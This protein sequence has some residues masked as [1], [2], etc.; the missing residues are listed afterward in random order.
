MQ[1]L[2]QHQHQSGAKGKGTPK[3]LSSTTEGQ[4]MLAAEQDSDQEARRHGRGPK[5]GDFVPDFTEHGVEVP[6]SQP[7]SALAQAQGTIK[8]IERWKA[9]MPT[10]QEMLPKDKYTIFDRKAKNYRKG[11]RSLE[12]MVILQGANEGADTQITQ[13][14]ACV[15]AIKSSWILRNCTICRYSSMLR[16]REFQRIPKQNIHPIYQQEY[17]PYCGF[18]S[19]MPI[20]RPDGERR[21]LYSNDPMTIYI[22]SAAVLNQL[23]NPVI[24]YQK[25]RHHL[26]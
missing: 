25:C 1:V 19:V 17:S 21:A 6:S 18:L 2:N 13:M 15:S 11:V 24:L 22:H 9:E 16:D 8:L 14:D 7:L 20:S 23:Q 3:E 4:T 10:E 26:I 12:R 5:Q